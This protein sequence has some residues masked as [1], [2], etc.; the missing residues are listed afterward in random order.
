M[1]C[2]KKKSH[3]LSRKNTFSSTVPTLCPFIGPPHTKTTIAIWNKRNTRILVLKHKNFLKKKYRIEE[4]TF[5]HLIGF[6]CFSK[7][8]VCNGFFLK[9][10]RYFV[11]CEFAIMLPPLQEQNFS[12]IRN[13][14]FYIAALIRF[15]EEENENICCH[16]TRKHYILLRNEKKNTFVPYSIF[17]N[18]KRIEKNLRSFAFPFPSCSKGKYRSAHVGLACRFFFFFFS[19]HGAQMSGDKRGR[20]CLFEKDFKWSFG[21]DIFSPTSGLAKWG[22]YTIL[23][24]VRVCSMARDILSNIWVNSR[25]VLCQEGK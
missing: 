8:C 5:L 2:C 4:D 3:S 15:K 13:S 14:S 9:K 18:K 11:V 17:A 20:R 16:A 7:R 6:T 10:T 21:Q 19:F 22:R 12:Y 25:H 23:S 1:C 24:I